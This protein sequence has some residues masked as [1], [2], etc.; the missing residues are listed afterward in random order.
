M[1]VFPNRKTEFA[2]RMNAFWIEPVK[3][4][5]M[6]YKLTNVAE[7]DE[8]QVGTPICTNEDNKTAVVCRYAYVVAVSDDRKI[9]TVNRGHNVKA[10]DTLVISGTTTTATVASVTADTITL[11][12]ALSQQNATAAMNNAL[13]AGSVAD[14]AASFKK[15]NR[16]VSSYAKIDKLHDT[17][18]AAHQGIVLKNVVNYPKEFLNDTTFPG[19]ILLVGNPLLMFTVQ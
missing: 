3:R 7:G 11:A 19:S 15:P 13:F 18:A 16:I 2:G 5:V 14:G 8:I 1:A 17:V 9:L 4:D 10:G 6:G 12:S